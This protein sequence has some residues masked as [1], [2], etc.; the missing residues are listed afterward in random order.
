MSDNQ[1]NNK[2]IAKNTVLLYFRMLILMVVNL[3]ASRVV[4]AALGVDDYGL[5]SVVG[6]VVAFLGFLNISMTSASQR[7]LSYSQGHDDENGVKRTFNSVFRAQFVIACTIVLLA[8]TLGVFYIQKYLNCDADRLYAAHI[9]FQFSLLSFVTKT[10]SVP[11]TASILAHERMNAFA[12]LSILEGGLQFV[13]A[14][15]LVYF[16]SDRLIIYG[17]GMALTVCLVQFGYRVYCKHYFA[18]CRLQRSSDRTQIIEIFKYSGW[19]LLGSLSAVAIDQGVNMILNGFFGVIVNAARGIAFQVSSAVTSLAGN[20]QQAL[21]PQIVKSYARN[22]LEK[23]H[24]LLMSGTRMC[25]FLL[26]LL[27][28][29]IFC[30]ITA[31]LPLWLGTVPEYTVLFCQLVIINAL[32]CSLS[33]CILTGVSATGNIKRYQIIVA[34]INLLN[35]PLSFIAL[36][37]YSD[38]YL[39]MYVMISVSIFAFCARLIIS[40]GMLQ[41]SKRIFLSTVLIPIVKV[42]IIM[43]AFYVLNTLYGY[44]GQGIVYTLSSCFAFGL[45][46]VFIIY[47]LGLDQHERCIVNN[48]IKTKILKKS[49]RPLED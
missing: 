42:I 39:T 8:E 47:F 23:L 30:N 15:S 22:E 7:F 34:S 48:I 26:L 28:F 24:S 3:Y 13:V 37:L 40:S 33:N 11:Y 32:I 49:H 35:F 29:P 16:T 45:F 5:Y 1:S 12:L 6:G 27:A 14:T 44:E 46:G 20:F 9:V 19:N 18:E 17:F 41:F 10:I 25:F 31:I 36:K 2:R 38:P 21:N 4:L 43:L